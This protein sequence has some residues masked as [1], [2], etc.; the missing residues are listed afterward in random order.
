MSL[1][2]S[3]LVVSSSCQYFR[4]G[5]V[6]LFTT[7]LLLLTAFE[8][9]KLG[10]CVGR[11]PP[12]VNCGIRLIGLPAPPVDTSSATVCPFHLQDGRFNAPTQHTRHCACLI[13]KSEWTC[14]FCSVAK[15]LAFPEGCNSTRGRSFLKPL[16]FS[17][18]ESHTPTRQ[19]LSQERQQGNKNFY[20]IVS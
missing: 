3:S 16:T 4:A 14:R 10:W 18:L 17:G 6:M 12:F 19:P 7:E 5:E 20:A 2:V 1:V 9:E 8:R 15:A 13:A 11:N